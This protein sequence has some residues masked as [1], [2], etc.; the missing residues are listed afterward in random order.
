MAQPESID[1]AVEQA[2]LTPKILRGP[3]G[4]EIQQ[5]SITDLIKAEQHEAAKAAAAS[6]T[7]TFGLRFA[8]TIPPGAG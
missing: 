3:G 5:H 6:A 8:K 4:R 7:S 1:E 2:A